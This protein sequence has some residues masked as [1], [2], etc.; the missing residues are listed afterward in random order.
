MH[1]KSWETPQ[2]YQLPR[3]GSICKSGNPPSENRGSNGI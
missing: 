1:E 2:K 3:F